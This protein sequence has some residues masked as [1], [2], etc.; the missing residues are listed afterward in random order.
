M[1]PDEQIASLGRRVYVSVQDVVTI[2]VGHQKL[3]LYADQAQSLLEQ[4]KYVTS[5]KF[6]ESRAHQ[7][8]GL[9]HYAPDPDT[10]TKG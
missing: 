4:L 6:K 3:L 2:V 9:V 5:P 8:R 7:E 10:T 1:Q